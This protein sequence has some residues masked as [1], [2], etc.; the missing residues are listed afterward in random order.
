MHHLER[1][2]RERKLKNIPHHEA[3]PRIPSTFSHLPGGTQWFGGVL[4]ADH[5]PLRAND[6]RQV[7]SDASGA[8]ANVEN[9]HSR[10]QVRQ[11]IAAGVRGGSHR[12]RGEGRGVM[13]VD[14]LRRIRVNRNRTDHERS[15]GVLVGP[16]TPD[17]DGSTR[18]IG[19]RGLS[20]GKCGP[21]C[22]RE[23]KIRRCSPGHPEVNYPE[24]APPSELILSSSGH[25]SRL[26]SRNL[27]R[28]DTGDRSTQGPPPHT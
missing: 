13:A 7:E 19:A 12:V 23:G 18:P 28:L 16:P 1:S 4:E 21:S 14:V 25:R 22:V 2:V 6:L 27:Q 20:A 3:D 24:Q 9:T 17:E 11:E 26:M 10:F 15:V 8:A 5:T